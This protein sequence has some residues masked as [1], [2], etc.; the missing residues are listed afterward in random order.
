MKNFLPLLCLL[1]LATACQPDESAIGLG[2][3]DPATLY[4]GQR[5]TLDCTA[6]TVAEDSLNTTNYSQ[7]LLG[8]C[9]DPTFGTAEAIVY[10]QLANTADGGLYFSGS[11]IDSCV[12][13]LSLEQPFPSHLAQQEVLHIHFEVIRLAE[14]MQNSDDY[15][16]YSFDSIPVDPSMV[17]F[18][19]VVDMAQTDTAVRI[20]LNSKMADLIQ[21]HDFETN[22]QLIDALRGIRIRLKGSEEMMFTLN[23]NAAQSGLFIYRSIEEEYIPEPDVLSIGTG[24]THFNRFV[25]S[26]TGPL[27]QLASLDSLDGS[28]RLY[29]EPMGGTRLRIRMDDAIRSFHEAHPNAVV[30][31]AEL[32]LPMAPESDTLRPE[33]LI[34]MKQVNDTLAAYIPDMTDPVT[35]STLNYKYQPAFDAYHL[36]ITQHVQLMLRNGRDLGTY[37]LINSRRSSPARAIFNGT[38]ASTPTRVIIVYT[39]L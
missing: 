7:G 38:S 5:D 30:H 6:Y 19:G 27:A 37:V 23:F 12:L 29:L 13:S 15:T 36:R 22:Q 26:H 10:A 25:I 33:S 3:Q 8:R 11:S 4:D 35:S 20:P 18:D 34:L 39:E 21:G 17:L 31:Y 32:Q 9:S 24:G 14:P 28:H 2:L 1:L 16:Y